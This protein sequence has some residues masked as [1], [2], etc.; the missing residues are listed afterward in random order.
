MMS[1]LCHVVLNSEHEDRKKSSNIFS[2]RLM[3]I[4]LLRISIATLKMN[5]QT[6]WADQA[7]IFRIVKG[8]D[9]RAVCKISSR[10]DT[11]G[12]F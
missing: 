8:V 10:S 11:Y 5:S 2:D 6:G 1:N 7:E 12:R 4:F 9:L 3:A